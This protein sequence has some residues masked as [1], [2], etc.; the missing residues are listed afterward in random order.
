MSTK[1]I[2]P[3][4]K[5]I[6]IEIDKKY[7]SLAEKYCDEVIYGDIENLN[8]KLWGVLCKAD[9]WIFGDTLEHL[10]NPWDLL[11]MI[12]ASMPSNAIIA[13]CIPNAQHWSLQVKLCIGEFRY[14]EISLWTRLIYAGLKYNY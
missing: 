6:G 3:N 11:N 5:Y 1:K 9:C 4:N 14:E 2:N 13:C 12:N 7:A 10:K 8:S